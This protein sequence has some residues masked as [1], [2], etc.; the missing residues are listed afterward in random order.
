MSAPLADLKFANESTYQAKRD[1]WPIHAV[2]TTAAPTLALRTRAT[3]RG[4]E[5]DEEADR[6]TESD[7]RDRPAHDHQGHVRRSARLDP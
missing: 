1:D 4:T 7:H 5:V 6:E 2:T 3:L